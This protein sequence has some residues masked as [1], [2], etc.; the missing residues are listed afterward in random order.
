M[1]GTTDGD[2]TAPTRR[3]SLSHAAQAVDRMIDLAAT[4][5]LKLPPAT[6]TYRVV[7]SVKVPMRDGVSLA[8][9]LYQVRG[10]A[11]GTILVRSPYGRSLPLAVPLARVF[12]AR[13][14]HVLFVSSR[15]TFGSE[16][17]FVPMQTE[18]DDGHDVVDWMRGQPWFTGSFATLG[19]SYLG[20]TQWALL[21]DPPSEQVAAVV[22]VG[23]HDFGRHAWGSGAFKL[24][25]LGWCNQILHQEDGPAPIAMMQVGRRARRLPRY[26]DELPLAAAGDTFLEGK[27]PW[28]RDWVTR[29]DL[30]DPFWAPTQ[31]GEALERTAV[32]V[33]LFGGWQDLFLEQTVEQ[34]RRLH[35]RGV[36]VAMTIGPWSH[37]EAFRAASLLTRETLEWLD[38]YLAGR[39]P[40]RRSGRVKV[41]V[42]GADQWQE[43]DSWPPPCQGLGLFLHPGGLLAIDQPPDHGGASSFTFDPAVPTPTIGGPLLGA[44]CVTD[45][46]ALA[47]RPD[48]VSFT[49]KTL[50]HDVD[51]VGTPTIAVWD[52]N[53]NVH[54]DLFA[55]LSEIDPTGTS[56]NVTEGF[57]RLD[58]ARGDGPVELA[59][60]PMAHRFR[61]GS[62]MR[63]VIAGGSHPQ[64]ARNLGT[65]DNPG[66]GT[67]L[68][69]A[70][71][72]IGHAAEHP[73]CL[74]LPV[75]EARG[76]LSADP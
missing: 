72:E 18:A 38:A 1:S 7:R 31:R 25:F 76:L 66:T 57:S 5:M 9:D 16:G 61:A 27:A 4:R 41:Y 26:L 73:S 10:Q 33:L 15:G 47:S 24:D 22:A 32:P 59:L 52:R 39:T 8:A 48:T 44:P 37:L 55:R 63:L 54:A 34:Y 67:A 20:H 11:A 14:Y 64:Y 21:A 56:R 45:D 65:G 53:D 68:R 74:T 62:R 30:S 36:E 35:E 12:A 50:E 42:T 2:Q 75:V 6:S 3:P 28:Y 43:L 71:H 19:P 23:P 69:T 49:G 40:C 60:R 70:R 17:Q 46:S 51:V 58:P 29:P 13:G